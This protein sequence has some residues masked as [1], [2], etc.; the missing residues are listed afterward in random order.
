MLETP[1]AVNIEVTEL[2]FRVL[3]AM[4][5]IAPLENM[6]RPH[7]HTVAVNDWLDRLSQKFGYKD[8]TEADQFSPSVPDSEYP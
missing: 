2:E 7:S 1:Q 4:S 3:I 8:A 6:G 5:T